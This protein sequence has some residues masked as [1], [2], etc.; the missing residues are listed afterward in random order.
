[1]NFEI[2][3]LNYNGKEL[4]SECLP[5]VQQA[6]KKTQLN[7]RLT[8][9]DNESADDSVGYLRQNFEGVGVRLSKNR[10]LCSFNEAVQESRAE[11]VVLLNNDIKV[12]PDFLEPLAEVFE[13][14][15]DAFLA[16][17]MAYTFDLQQYEGSLSK[18]GFRAGFPWGLTRFPGYEDKIHRAG[19]TM[20]SGFGAFRREF[21]LKLGGYDDLFL[22]GTVEDMDICFRAWKAGHAC[23]YVPASRVYHKGQA[24]FKKSFGRARLLALNQRNLHLF[25]W[26]NISEPLLLARYFLWLPFRLL[27]FLVQGRYEFFWGFLQAWPRL[28]AALGRRRKKSSLAVARSDREIFRI[29]EVI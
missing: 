27:F 5:S 2:F 22:P 1:M 6:V 24:T 15:R 19:F 11:I 23:Y 3:V 8:V 12:E 25:V 13:T 21:F 4:L 28:P 14:H 29:S 26:K 10:V 16:A 17:P 20:L 18:F 7:C 9:I